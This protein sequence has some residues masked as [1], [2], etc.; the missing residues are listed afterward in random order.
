MGGSC[1]SVNEQLLHYVEE[2]GLYYEQFGL[3]RT[4]G[5]VLGWLLVCDPPRQTMNELVEVLQ[6]SKSSISSASRV[7]IQTGLADRISLPGKRRDYYRI[8][9]DAWIRGWE[10]Q[11]QQ[12]PQMRQMAERG[13]ALLDS[14][15]DI[16]KKRLVEMHELYTFMEVESPKLLNRY[17]A[18]RQQ[19]NE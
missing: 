8:N 3:P 17:R 12:A 19:K 2:F 16:R 7:L 6:V 14:E 15:S 1:I 13:L 18:L 4:A 10:L 5:R 11:I 9:E